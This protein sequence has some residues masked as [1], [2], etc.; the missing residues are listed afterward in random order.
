MVWRSG[1]AREGL[2]KFSNPSSEEIE[3]NKNFKTPFFPFY[4]GLTRHNL[5]LRGV[6]LIFLNNAPEDIFIVF[7]CI[8]V[9]KAAV[10]YQF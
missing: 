1:D 5:T 9:W 2:A 6:F 8:F 4:L 7:I 3:R 10:G